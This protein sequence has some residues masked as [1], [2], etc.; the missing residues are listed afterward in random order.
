MRYRVWSSVSHIEMQL[1]EGCVHCAR[2]LG[3]GGGRGGS[4]PSGRG[5]AAKLC[6]MKRP[7][8]NG[9]F[10]LWS[11]SNAC[12][13]ADV[14]TQRQQS[15]CPAGLSVDVTPSATRAVPIVPL[16]CYLWSCSY[17]HPTCYFDKLRPICVWSL[18]VS[19]V[20]SL[21]GSTLGFHFPFLFRFFRRDCPF[22]LILFCSGWPEV[23]YY[24]VR[25]AKYFLIFVT[26]V[27]H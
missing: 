26:V 22:I 7:Q 25:R 11:S 24:L 10:I 9:S 20:R 19:P 21:P 4:G 5:S 2:L 27:C 18:V 16:G 12:A 14:H 8:V 23:N 6:S 1:P 13:C 3:G 15:V 17:L